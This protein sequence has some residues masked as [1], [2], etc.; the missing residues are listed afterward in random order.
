MIGEL[1]ERQHG[2]VARR[3]LLERGFTRGAIE[4]RVDRGQLY[5]V[6][7][8][9]YAV[10]HRLLAVHGRWM[11]A[12]LACG[13][14][15]VLSRRSAGQLWGIVPMASRW[16]E[17]T[18]PSACRGLDGISIH[19]GLL[20]PDERG[21]LVGIPVTSVARTQF[22]LAGMLPKRGLERAMHEA[23][24]KGLTDRLSLWDL[25]ERYPRRRG[26]GNLRAVLGAKMPVGITQTELEELFVEFLDEYG[27]PRPR[28]NPTLPV[29]GRLL[30]PDC[31]WPERRLLAELDGREI[32][33]TDEAFE[34]DRQRD[35]ILLVEGWRSTRIT[36]R[37]LRVERAEIAA[38]L[39][40]LLEGQSLRPA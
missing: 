39:R 1:A 18:R 23:E 31:M 33:G 35:R 12:V 38:D 26:A 29:R 20:P 34:S 16:P 14:D 19:R 6:H 4:A 2:L 30:R 10:G 11:A 32:H 24:V 22:D 15:A 40:D 7:Q 21:E 8:G 27:L 17:V 9:V 5:V 25:L 3:Q 37:Q 36:W 13:P 28:L